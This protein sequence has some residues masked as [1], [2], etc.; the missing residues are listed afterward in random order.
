MNIITLWACLA[1]EDTNEGRGRNYEV[2]YAST[3]DLALKIIHNPTYYKHHGVQSCEPD[4]GGGCYVKET[5]MVVYD[6]LEEYTNDGK[7]KAIKT[8]LGK[9]TDD[10]KILLGLR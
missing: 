2:C 9:L 5:K 4:K 8:A 1:N 10:E 6:T 7:N 3:K